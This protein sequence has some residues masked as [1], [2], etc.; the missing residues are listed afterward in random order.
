MNEPDHFTPP[1][2]PRRKWPYLVAALV[3]VVGG[4]FAGIKVSDHLASCGSGVKK[5]G[6]HDE[7][8]GVSDGSY[9]FVDAL[10][11]VMKKIYAENKRVE[12][13][14]KP[15]V[16]VAYVEPITDDPAQEQSRYGVRE[17]LE[18]AYL[19][20]RQLNDPQLGGLGDTPQIRLL[21]ANSGLLSEQYGPLDNQL[22]AMTK[23]R[24]HLVAI[25]GFGQSRGGTLAMVDALR[26]KVPMVG[27]TV[28]ADNL[29][30]AKDVGFFRVAV[31][32]S[33]QA[34]AGVS[35]LK[36]Q[37]AAHHG[38][39]VAVVRDRNE[40]DLYN[41]TLYEG[42]ETA[43]KKQ[44]L[45]LS[46]G[47][48]QYVSNKNGISNAFSSVADQICEK[49]VKAVY[50]A[51]RGVSLRGFITAMSEP[52]RRCQ[53]TV[54]TGDDAVGV[55]EAPDARFAKNWQSSG[56]TA[57]Y[58]ALGHPGLPDEIYGAGHN[59][60]LPFRDL[61]HKEFGGSGDEVFEDG[62]AMLA[63]DSI[64]TLG[65]AIQ[66]AAGSSGET[67]VD[68][69]STLNALVSSKPVNGVTGPTAL[70]ADGNPQHKLMALVKLEPNGKYDFQ[71][72]VTP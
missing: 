51:G 3:V 13:S 53:V 41:T 15:W 19:A 35:Y 23:D 5:A 63:H 67:P 24:N 20:Q 62:Q 61:Y 39:T 42:F 38:Y 45:Q 34:S 10:V 17:E 33:E 1:P 37:Q 4:V 40:N 48:L 56:V 32:N 59:P 14:G 60:Y 70:G 11:P 64:W 21:V 72:P 57:L 16:S 26:G 54:L 65:V 55:Y 43:A 28:T 68:T 2:A 25:A 7:C 31:P 22:I 69:G 46:S 50:F 49:H 27:A 47:D 44:G 52:S 6:P 29:V 9:H 18:G 58:T 12:S 8:V 71:T 30:S 66:N 36:K